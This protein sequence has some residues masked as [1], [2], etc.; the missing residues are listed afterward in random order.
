MDYK[1][2]YAQREVL[3]GRYRAQLDEYA[4]ILARITGYQVK[5]K[6]MYSF[7][8]GKE[9]EVVDDFDA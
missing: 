2:D 1:T 3:L 9:I 5:E 6:I 4:V 7:Y 8:L